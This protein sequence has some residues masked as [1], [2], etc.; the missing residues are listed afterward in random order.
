[1]KLPLYQVDAFTGRLFRG[2]PAAVCP[3]EEWL[4]DQTMQDIAAENNLA[5]TAFFVREPGG[6]H[7]RWFTPEVE[8]DLCGHATLASAYVV[9][10]H[11]TPEED[12]VRFH[13]RSGELVVARK[14]DLYSLDLPARPPNP[15]DAPKELAKAL[16]AQPEEVWAARDY[17]AVFSNEE[18]ILSMEPDFNALAKLDKFAV[19]VTAPGDE[20]DF[21]SR[22]FAPAKGINEDPVTGSAHCSL[23]PYWSDSLGKESLV[24]RQL[25]RRGGELLCE[26]HGDRVKLY[27]KATLYLTG[28][29][30]LNDQ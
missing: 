28:M 9:L 11:I 15:C 3:L 7:L 18:Q 10:N 27:G 21:V 14:E 12:E 13:T 1:M 6:Y 8:V 4:D 5:E 29:I 19:I 25:S 17:M 24:A 23:V 16:G 22:F 2:N 30:H 26:D 20:V